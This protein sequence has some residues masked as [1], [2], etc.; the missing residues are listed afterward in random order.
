MTAIYAAQYLR[1]S[2]EHQQYS[3]ESQA[4]ALSNTHNLTVLQSLTLIAILR[5]A[6]YGLR[7]DPAF[8]NCC[9]MSQKAV[10]LT[11]PFWFMTLAG[12]DDSKILT[13]PPTMNL[14]ANQL[15]FRFTDA[16]RRLPMTACQVR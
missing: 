5:K 9:E 10:P 8:G 12:R 16:R 4:L 3:T 13:R 11:K 14:C 7:G 1:M 2:T 15:V 6:P